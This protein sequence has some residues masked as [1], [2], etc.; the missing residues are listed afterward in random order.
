MNMK[1]LNVYKFGLCSVTADKM[2]GCGCDEAV[3]EKTTLKRYCDENFK[4]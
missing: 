2:G 1:G 3:S 4:G